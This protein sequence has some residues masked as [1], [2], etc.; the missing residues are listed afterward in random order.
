MMFAKAEL[1]TNMG[2]LETSTSKTQN[3]RVT[4]DLEN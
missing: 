1:E 3:H 2:I 4:L